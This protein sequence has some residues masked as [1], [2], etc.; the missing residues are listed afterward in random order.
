ML[1]MHG[2]ISHGS[3]AYF[4]SSTGFWYG[5]EVNGACYLLFVN[6]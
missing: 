6:E 1:D 3:W 2:F 4:Y 5:V